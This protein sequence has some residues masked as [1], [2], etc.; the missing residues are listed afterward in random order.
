MVL[1]RLVYGSQT[2]PATLDY[3]LD[4]SQTTLSKI[5]DLKINWV[6]SNSRLL[7]RS[8]E[9]PIMSFFKNLTL[10]REGH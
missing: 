1:V 3:L 8:Q 10:R 2:A 4:F 9:I 5:Q 7:T 6:N